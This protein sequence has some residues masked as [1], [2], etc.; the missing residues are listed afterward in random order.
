MA[1]KVSRQQGDNVRR[2][3]VRLPIHVA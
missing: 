1:L 3:S 2:M